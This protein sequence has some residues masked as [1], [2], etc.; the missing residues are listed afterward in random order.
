MNRFASFVIGS[1]LLSG[2]ASAADFQVWTY[3]AKGSDLI[4]SVSFMGD[5]K[6]QEAMIDLAIPAGYRIVDSA[7]KM[8]GSVCAA[9]AEKGLMRVVPP[10]GEDKALGKSMTDVCSFRLA[11]TGEKIGGTPNIDVAFSECFGGGAA[12]TCNVQSTDVSQ[13]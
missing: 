3:A 13:K 2:T 5:G 11:S 10:S 12:A 9:S 6:T 8:S 4:V 7:V 1:L